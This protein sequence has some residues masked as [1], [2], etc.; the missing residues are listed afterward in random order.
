MATVINSWFFWVVCAIV[1]LFLVG[2]AW[3]KQLRWIPALAVRAVLT[4]LALMVVFIPKDKETLVT[5]V[6]GGADQPKILLLDY[7]DSVDNK[8]KEAVL[9]QGLKWQRVG[10]KRLFLVF[11]QRALWIPSQHGDSVKIQAD[12]VGLGA[13][14]SKVASLLGDGKGQIILAT[15]GAFE[16]DKALEDS[17]A[18]LKQKGQELSILPLKAKYT[19]ADSFVGMIQA[20]YYV[21]QNTTFPVILPVYS[22]SQ[23]EGT[24]PTFQVFLNGEEENIKAEKISGNYTYFM[25]PARKEGI[26]TV[27]IKANFKADAHEENNS[28]ATT[29]NVLSTPKIAWVTSDT[30]PIRSLINELTSKGLNISLS[31]PDG[32]PASVEEL[33]S[34]K[35]IVL[36]NLLSFTLT[37]EQMKGIIEFV[38]Q[39]GGLIFVG[40]KNAYTLGGYKNSP[41]EP[42][43]PVKL[44]A[45]P[46][47][48]RDPIL[49]LIIMDS[50]GSMRDPISSK[51]SITSMMLAQEAAIRTVETLNLEDY[52]GLISFATNVYWRVDVQEIHDGVNLRRT[53]DI[54]SKMSGFGSTY[55]LQAI[56][57]AKH[58]FMKNT[59]PLPT[60]KYILLLSDG[61][62][63]DGTLDGF[64]QYA[65]ELNEKFEIKISTI[66]LGSAADQ[67]VMSEIAKHG[68]GRY[69]EVL[70]P[71]QLPKIM[72]SESKAARAENVQDGDTSL[73]INIPQHPILYGLSGSQL[74][75]VTSYNALSSKAEIGAE[76]ILVSE[77]YGDPL[78][79]AWQYGLGRVVTWMSTSTLDWLKSWSSKDVE[80]AFWTQILKYSLPSPLEKDI[81]FLYEVNDDEL[82]IEVNLMEGVGDLNAISA[83]QFIYNDKEGKPVTVNLEQS[84]FGNYTARIP[85]PPFGAYKGSVKV[86]DRSNNEKQ[87]AASFSVNPS[88]EVLPVDEKQNRQ[89]LEELSA[90]G[91][92]RI[93]TEEALA[94]SP[95]A[96]HTEAQ[97]STLSVMKDKTLMLGAILGLWML[98]IAIRRRWLPWI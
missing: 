60:H 12:G 63:T 92:G 91:H 9:E 95:K 11:N 64:I 53:Q 20:P 97:L 49:M 40:G 67:V 8:D 84:H 72:I 28:S 36:D 77:S 62:S 10:E 21:W 38:K 42:I 76:D 45:P 50:S 52:L 1:L 93:I 16:A 70:D 6:N 57:E 94:Q 59:S 75:I 51:S 85:R 79:S 74:P 81:Q 35:I 39:G 83:V 2:I 26:L 31:K 69:Y 87:F 90:Q 98:D 25:L 7:S 68:K 22:A 48:S 24:E 47:P 96:E 46:R 88:K 89:K 44:E 66:A 80:L 54:I 41:L 56:V 14:L 29:I 19:T 17:L 27:E 13:V 71:N 33:Q 15:D 86:L 78:L 37:P 73:K 58:Y 32:L 5:T 30:A 4:I 65:D 61:K 23:Q 82:A 55:M 3:Y 43:F 18:Q 34:Y